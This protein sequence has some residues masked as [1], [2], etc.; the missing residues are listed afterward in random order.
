[1]SNYDSHAWLPDKETGT[2]Y[3]SH[4]TNHKSL[5][6]VTFPYVPKTETKEWIEENL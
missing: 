1:M 3:K 4:F 5:V 6:P 2:W